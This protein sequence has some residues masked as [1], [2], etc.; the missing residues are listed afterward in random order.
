VQ[1]FHQ[2]EPWLAVFSRIDT[3]DQARVENRH[4]CKISFCCPF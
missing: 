3:L 4:A 2:F 1:V